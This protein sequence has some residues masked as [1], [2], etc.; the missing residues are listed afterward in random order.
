M[1][2]SIQILLTAMIILLFHAAGSN[3]AIYSTLQISDDGAGYHEMPQINNNNTLVWLSTYQDH[4]EIYMYKGGGQIL[5][6]DNLNSY[7]NPKIN[8]NDQ[9][10]W[11]IHDGTDYEIFLYDGNVTIQLTD[12]ETDDFGPEIANNGSIVWYGFDGS[13]YEIFL[14][15]GMDTLQLTNNEYDDILLVMN[16]KNINDSGMVVWSG[17][18]GSD[19]EIFLYNGSETLQL[20]DNDAE[21][22][23]PQINNSGHCV[24]SYTSVDVN[25]IRMFDGS[26]ITSL[27]SYNLNELYSWPQINDQDQVTWSQNIGETE[28]NAIFLYDG[29]TVHQLSDHGSGPKINNLGYVTWRGPDSEIILYDGS[30]TIQLTDNVS[31]LFSQINDN[32]HV[33]WMGNV[34]VTW[35]ILYALPSIDFLIETIERINPAPMILNTYMAHLKKIDAFIEGEK[36]EATVNQLENFIHKVEKDINEELI[37]DEDGTL[38]IN[39]VHSM[40]DSLLA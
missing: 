18:D 36:E 25:E 6:A 28:N 27:D 39:I 1:K 31:N 3:A 37:S 35:Q 2:Q 20:T 12:N 22:D 23:F 5:L 4:N 34:G 15:S 32:G 13:D 40:I 24:W 19:Y 29:V 10:V 14:Y 26:S 30:S 21:D 17:F 9:V 7:C 33:V 38:L 16:G 11:S 8:D